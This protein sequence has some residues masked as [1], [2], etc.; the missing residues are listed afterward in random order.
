MSMRLNLLLAPR[1]VTRQSSRFVS[2][3]Q[4]PDALPWG[5]MDELIT[6]HRFVDIGV[7]LPLP[8]PVSSR[9]KSQQLSV[10]QLLE[11]LRTLDGWEPVESVYPPKQELRKLYTF[12][13]FDRSVAFMRFASTARG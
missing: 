1:N 6:A 12:D 11:Q 13:S 8:F 10:A 3:K 2:E 4:H 9:R 7:A 5:G